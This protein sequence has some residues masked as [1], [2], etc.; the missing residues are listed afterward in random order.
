[1]IGKN[2]R[3][4]KV[5]PSDIPNVIVA[6][7]NVISGESDKFDMESIPELVHRNPILHRGDASPLR[8]KVRGVSYTV[9]FDEHG[10]V[11]DY[12]LHYLAPEEYN[13]TME[14]YKPK[15]L[16]PRT[17]V[18]QALANPDEPVSNEVAVVVIMFLQQT[19]RATAE[20]NPMYEILT[21]RINKLQLQ[22]DF[23][24]DVL[25]KINPI[26][27]MAGEDIVDMNT[28]KVSPEHSLAASKMV[29]EIRQKQAAQLRPYNRSNKEK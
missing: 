11:S 1:M 2:Y 15:E 17:T 28:V 26:K 24:G 14:F 23:A 22:L 13:A 4:G 27:N 6:L 12:S 7:S 20:D 16:P 21:A 10:V 18:R 25:N 3:T 19:L 9:E 8:S 5:H 29:T